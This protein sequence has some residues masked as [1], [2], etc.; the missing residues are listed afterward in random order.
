MKNPTMSSHLHLYN[1]L[2]QQ[3]Q[4]FQPKSPNHASVYVCGP[5][6]YDLPHAGHAR[7]AIA[8]D[9]LVRHLQASGLQTTFVRNITDIDDKILARA[10]Q[11]GEDPLQLSARMTQIYLDDISAINCL[12]PTHQP[13]VS[14]HI[15]EII[16]LVQT[17]IK[18]G[19]AYEVETPNGTH[20]I[21]FSVRSFAQYGKLSKRKLDDL[22]TGARVEINDVKRDP[23]DFALWK[24]TPDEAYGWPSPWGKGRPG[25]HIECSA[26]SAKYL[27]FGFDIHGG[28]MDL[29][30]PHHENEI[31]QSEAAN[32][33]QG[34]F[35]KTWMHNGFVNVDKEKMSKSLGNF[36]TIRD[37]LLRNDPE[38][39][40]YFLLTVQYRGPLTFDSDKLPNGRIVFPGVDEAER[41]IDYLYA[42]VERLHTIA[43]SKSTIPTKLPTELATI[44]K[45]ISAA[46]NKV[47]TALDDDL[48]TPVA[49]AAISEL[50]KAANDLCDLSIKRRKDPAFVSATKPIAAQALA[51]FESCTDVLGILRAPVQTYAERTRSRRIHIRNIN[52]Q[53]IEN[54]ITERAEARK[55]KDFSRADSIRKELEA[56]G[57]EIADSTDSTTWKVCI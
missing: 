18:N 26:M 55:Q 8:F 34:P 17:L 1:T 21:Y 3:T 35:A 11:S 5:T 25:W 4:P 19:A 28:G 38:A 52:E 6:V 47:A 7:S 23:L 14:D 37:V 22:E 51:A 45:T 31:A 15:P 32:P 41:R 29:I 43:D 12:E 39:F 24:G 36:V 54:K 33:N 2:E 46:R 49:L 48:N 42:T 57:I 10:Q 30:F 16:E 9:I 53:D 40:R 13:K 44:R 56:S 50:A 20:D 27:G